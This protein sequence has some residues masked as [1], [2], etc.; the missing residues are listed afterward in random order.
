M[1][2]LDIFR[3]S[4]IKSE[5]SS[6]KSKLAQAQEEIKALNL[7]FE[8]TGARDALVLKRN[9]QNY[10]LSLA[11]LKSKINE[12]EIVDLPSNAQFITRDLCCG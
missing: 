9:I 8:E 5:L 7:E 2:I 4:S 12:A 1:S 11:S 3:L 6:K 10:E